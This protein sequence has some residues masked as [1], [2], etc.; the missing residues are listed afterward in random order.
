MI[1]LIPCPKTYSADQDKAAAPGETLAKVKARLATL[2]AAIL[3]ETRRIDSGRLG[4]PVFLS[5][6]AEDARAVMPTR[7]QMGKG[8]SPEQAEASA[9]MEL[10][11]RYGFFTFWQRLPECLE[12]T[13]N[14]AEARFGQALMPLEEIIRACHDRIAPE[15]AR[16]ILNLRRWL[17]FPVTRIHDG[18]VVHAPLDLFKQLGEFNGSSAGNTDVEVFSPQSPLGSAIIGKRIGETASYSA[19][20]GKPIDVTIL[21]VEP[22]V[23]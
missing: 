16:R 13:F 1:R 21:E 8:A 4:I 10:M 20:N 18:A 17:F 14:E 6:C 7:K 9:L 23:D 2:D 15:A 11:E 12:L 5:V 3:A 19:P 22:Y